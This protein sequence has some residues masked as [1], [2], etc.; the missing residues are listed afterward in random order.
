MTDASPGHPTLTGSRPAPARPPG[1]SDR[2]SKAWPE[3]DAAAPAG[4]LAAAMA[5]GLVGALTLPAAGRPGINLIICG[6]VLA[7]ATWPFARQRVNRTAATFAVLALVLAAVP[8]L[9]DAPWIIGLC[10]ALCAPLASYALTGGRTWFEVL[11]GGLTLPVAVLRMSP[12]AGRGAAGAA[13]ARRGAV[14]PAAGIAVLAGVVLLAVFGALFAGADAAFRVLLGRLTPEMSAAS[15]SFRLLAFAGVA[16]WFLA[17]VFLAT[18]PPRLKALAPPP[19]RPA[20]R[21]PWAAPLM[22]LDLLFVVFCAVQAVVFMAADKDRLLASTGLTYAQYARQGFFQLVIITVLVLGV[23]AGAMRYAPRASRLDRIVVR[24]LLGLLCALT[25]VVVAVALR[26]LFLYEEVFG[27]TRLRLWV[28]AFELWLGLVVLLVAAAGIR[29]RAT[30]LP[31]AVAVSGAA[32]LAGLAVMNPDGFIASHNVA[33]FQRVGDIDTRYL[34]GLSADAVPALDRL[35]EP[36]RSCA[37]RPVAR[38]LRPAEPWLGANLSRAR[39]RT[40][41]TRRPAVSGAECPPP[42]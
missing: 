20:G 18:A 6:S 41:L 38:R 37:L 42:R 27:W 39:A 17:A 15:A 29:L 40:I 24:T 12:W 7:V 33:R 32:A 23:V 5:T 9:R 2:L 1:W 25:L 19:G 8:A 30:W 31:R 11:G 13:T 3:P 14:S 10:L 26:R 35:P 16:T 4:V 36:Y 21:W 34:A 22:A 28:H